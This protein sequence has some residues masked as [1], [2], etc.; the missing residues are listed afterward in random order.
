MVDKKVNSKSYSNNKTS[1]KDVALKE[2]VGHNTQ[3]LPHQR[4]DQYLQYW[5]RY[6]YSWCSVRSEAAAVILNLVKSK[7]K[8]LR[9]Q[10]RNHFLKVSLKTEQSFIKHFTNRVVPNGFRHRSRSVNQWS[11]YKFRLSLGYNKFQLGVW[12]TDRYFLFA[13]LRWPSWFRLT[14]Q[15]WM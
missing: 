9:S 4:S 13:L 2:C 6:S 7:N 8:S 15:S 12:K 1:S 10:S 5:K 3:L 11:V 14:R